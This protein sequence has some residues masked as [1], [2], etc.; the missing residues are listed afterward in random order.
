MFDDELDDLVAYTDTVT[1]AQKVGK[2]DWQKPLYGD[3]ITVKAR[4]DRG[5]IYSGTNNDRQIVANAVIYLRT[6]LNP[7]MPV[8][9][10]DWLQG[11]AT[12]DGHSYAITTVDTLMDAG[13]PVIW[14]YELEVL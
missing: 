7:N 14:G 13:M 3:P 11:S 4:V 8:L 2:D 10:P 1:L 5:T 12:F 9:G 6:K